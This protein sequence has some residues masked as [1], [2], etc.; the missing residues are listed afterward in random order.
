MSI[1]ALT[2]S[3]CPITKAWLIE[4]QLQGQ[5]ELAETPGQKPIPNV[6]TSWIPGGSFLGSP[7]LLQQ[8]VQTLQKHVFFFVYLV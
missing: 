1:S 3:S 7:L 6:L 2:S 4:I 8:L 5:Q